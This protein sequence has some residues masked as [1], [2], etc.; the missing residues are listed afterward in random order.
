MDRPDDAL[1]DPDEKPGGGVGTLDLPEDGEEGEGDDAIQPAPDLPS[2]EPS[3]KELAHLADHVFT[4]I[5]PSHGSY[6]FGSSFKINHG[7]TGQMEEIKGLICIADERS[8]GPTEYDHH[9]TITEHNIGVYDLRRKIPGHLLQA[10]GER[11]LMIQHGGIRMM[12]IKPKDVAKAWK[13]LIVLMEMTE[14]EPDRKNMV[15]EYALLR[16]LQMVHQ[17]PLFGS[18]YRPYEDWWFEQQEKLADARALTERTRRRAEANVERR[19]KA[20]EH[21]A[22]VR[23]DWS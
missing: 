13:A 16:C 21:R 18:R 14:Y 22:R 6:Q 9:Q 15:K 23:N 4:I 11:W 1:P 17:N 7:Q 2:V 8:D 20:G 3:K 10:H 19:S 12:D 5:G